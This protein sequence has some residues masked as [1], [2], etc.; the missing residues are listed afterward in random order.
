MWRCDIGSPVLEIRGLGLSGIRWNG[1][2][3]VVG[4]IW[5]V[6]PSGVVTISAGVILWALVIVFHPIGMF[7]TLESRLV[8]G[9]NM[10]LNATNL[11]K[12]PN[13][14]HYA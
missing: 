13:L 5:V 9:K 14:K 2:V 6:S 3:I 12:G 4:E 11:T 10:A 1:V 8:L 7:N